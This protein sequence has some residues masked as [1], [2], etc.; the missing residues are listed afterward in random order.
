MRARALTVILGA[1]EGKRMRSILPKVLHRIGGKPLLD[2]VVQSALKAGLGRVIVVVGHRR[3]M[4][5]EE[6]V[7]YPIEIVVQEEQHGTGHAMQMV[8]EFLGNYVGACLVVPGDAPFLK[9]QTMRA[10]VEFHQQGDYAATLLTAEYQDPS[11]YGRVIR[12]A[13]G[14]VERIVEDGDAT[15]E[16]RAVREINSGVYVF[17][18]RELARVLDELQANNRQGEFYI[19]DT[20]AALRAGGAQVGVVRAEDPVEVMGVNDPVHLREAERIYRERQ[21]PAPPPPPRPHVNLEYD[22]EEIEVVEQSVLTVEDETSPEKAGDVDVEPS[23]NE[24]EETDGSIEDE[25]EDVGTRE[26]SSGEIE[27]G[28]GGGRG[29]LDGG[30]GQT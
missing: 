1:G 10:L 19:T 20:I 12:D 9:P 17:D 25:D 30:G 15:S 18:Y 11:G 26:L 8:R 13:A 14:E 22:E 21:P 6:L 24:D 3:D 2:H 27:A 16:E 23:I 5:I 7:D 29:T 28:F 4:V